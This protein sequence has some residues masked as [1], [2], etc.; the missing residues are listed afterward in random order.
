[1]DNYF[2]LRIII[3]IL[4]LLF[5]SA[6]NSSG[7][8][9]NSE[10]YQKA[11]DQADEIDLILELLT[12]ATN[13]D[14]LGQKIKKDSLIK[15]GNMRN[16]INDFKDTSENPTQIININEVMLSGLQLMTN[17]HFKAM[18][19]INSS[20]IVRRARNPLSTS[21]AQAK[22][23]LNAN[24]LNNIQKSF[25]NFGLSVI[26]IGA[27]SADKIVTR[28]SIDKIAWRLTPY[29]LI[30]L[31]MVYVTH[32]TELEQIK[33]YLPKPIADAITFIKDFIGTAPYISKKDNKIAAP[34]VH[35]RNLYQDGT[36]SDLNNLLN[37]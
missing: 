13:K 8:N 10:I 6:I 27:R 31:Y 19:D 34:K 20:L 36:L 37:S 11:L 1:M 26:N 9:Q 2:K 14:K 15:L 16:I 25:K 7:L 24:K 21:A 32:K 22:L 5:I 12:E 17:N 23:E 28:F 3:P 33:S 18:P 29:V 30:M 4:T 35:D